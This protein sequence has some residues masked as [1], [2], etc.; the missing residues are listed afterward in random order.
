MKH[1]DLCRYLFVCF[2]ISS[3]NI[4]FSS[5]LDQSWITSSSGEQFCYGY[6]YLTRQFV[7]YPSAQILID[8]SVN[9]WQRR[10][11]LL[12]SFILPVN[13]S[14][15]VYAQGNDILFLVFFPSEKI[16]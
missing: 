8:S 2:T 7:T 16:Y 4:F 5:Q 15:H 9:L 10:Y 6:L 11:C 14:H 12:L 13:K 3:E 1:K